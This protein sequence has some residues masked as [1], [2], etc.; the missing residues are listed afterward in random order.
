[1]NSDFASPFVPVDILTKEIFILGRSWIE[2][3]VVI[4]VIKAVVGRKEVRRKQSVITAV[5]L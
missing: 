1:M 4:C 3:V 5:F 2:L